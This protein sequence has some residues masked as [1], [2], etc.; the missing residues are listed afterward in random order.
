MQEID[1]LDGAVFDFRDVTQFDNSNLTSA[2]RRSEAFN[3]KF[4]LSRIPA[5]LIVGDSYQQ[6]MMRISL[7]IS[8]QQNRKR[9]VSSVEDAIKFIREFN[10]KNRDA[11]E[12]TSN[13]DPTKA[14]CHYDKEQR[15]LYVTYLNELTPEITGQV[16]NYIGS[17]LQ[18]I[19]AEAILGGIF[20]FRQVKKFHSSNVSTVQR[21]STNLNVNYDMSHI[22]VALIANGLQ[23]E[24]TVRISMRVT[25]QEHRKRIVNSVEDAMAFITEFHKK[26]TQ[27]TQKVDQDE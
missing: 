25:P 8:P 22:A 12:I 10:S 27:S 18:S 9:I 17:L 24:N 1:V 19:G 14:T 16:Y 3:S 7:N 26:R 13:I 11:D 23:Q 4:D 2:Q 5:A 6:R 15:I 20:D 21:T